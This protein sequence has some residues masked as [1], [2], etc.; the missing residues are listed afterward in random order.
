MRM[1][2]SF[3]MV[4]WGVKW[5]KEILQSL[6]KHSLIYLPCSSTSTAAC[7]VLAPLDSDRGD[8][9]GGDLGDAARCSP[10]STMAINQWL[11]QK[12]LSSFARR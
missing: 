4:I 8:A 12:T 7:S 3:K 10:E 9:S 2:T 6:I 5:G 1:R 11:Q